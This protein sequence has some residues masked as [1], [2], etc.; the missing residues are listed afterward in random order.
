[1]ASRPFDFVIVGGGS[2]GCALANRLSADPSNRVLV[3]EADGP[4]TRGTSTSTCRRRSRS[5]SATVLRLEVRVRTGTAHA[6]PPDLP[7]SGKVP[8]G[9]SSINGM[10]FQRGNLDYER[11][12]ADPGMQTWDYAHCLPTSAGWSTASRPSRTT[13]SRRRRP[14]VLERGPA[15]NPLFGA[16]FEAARQAGFELDRRRERLPAGGVRGVRPEHPPR[17]PAVGG[18]RLP[19]PG[20]VAPEPEVRTR[21][22]VSRILFEGSRAVGVEAARGRG[23]TARIDAGEVIVAAARSTLPQTLQL[24]GSACPTSS[25]RSID[26]VHD[27]PG[28]GENLQDHLE[29]YIQHACTQPVSMAPYLKWR[30]RPWIGFRWLFF[31]SGPGATNHFEGGGF[32]RSNDDVGYPNL[33]FHFLPI[34]GALR[35]LGAGERSRLPGPHRADVLGRTGFG[36][37]HESRPARPSRPALQLPVDRPGPARVGRGDPH[38]AADPRSARDGAVRRGDL[39]R[40]R[41]A[42]GRADPRVGRRRRRDRPA[43]LVH[44]QDGDRRDVGGRPSTMRVHGLDG[45]RVVDASVFPYVTNGNIYAPVMMVAE[46]AADLILGTRRSL[47][48]R[49]S[50]SAGHEPGR[51]D[52]DRRARAASAPRRRAPRPRTDRHQALVEER[53][54]AQHGDERVGGRRGRHDRYQADLGASRVDHRSQQLDHPSERGEPKRR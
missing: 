5:R 14:L 31:R 9:S 39:A 43:S 38:G 33:M 2:A 49:S 15:T 42:D 28:V 8:G 46:K 44:L 20:E 7:R 13:S 17:A 25:A 23:A 35:R 11:W 29:V 53:D 26:V 24:S 36:E 22:F 12:S 52:E 51:D 34:A 54:A 45:L 18:G 30:Y 10:I 40:P 48:R 3:L 37:D 19:A 6:R 32:A 47:P 50:S 16:F 41:R 4:T 1:M 27:L 21:T